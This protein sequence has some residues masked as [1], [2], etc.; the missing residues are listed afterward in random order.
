VGSVEEV[1]AYAAI[2]WY[3]WSKP[4][5]RSRRP[6][7]FGGGGVISHVGARPAPAGAGR[8][9]CALLC[10]ART[11]V[12]I[13]RMSSQRKTS[14]KLCV[15]LL[16][17]PRTRKHTGCSRRRASSSGARLL[18]DPALARIR[19]HVTKM[20]AAVRELDEEEHIQAPQPD[21]VYAEEVA[22]DDR[23]RLRPQKL[24][25]AQLRPQRRRFDPA[26]ASNL[27]ANRRVLAAENRTW[28]RI[29]SH[30]ITRS[31]SNIARRS[32][33]KLGADDRLRLEAERAVEGERSLKVGDAEREHVDG[34]THRHVGT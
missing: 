20:D 26:K 6:I 14:S 2:A 29:C 25:P 16:S 19:G 17:R 24:R 1:A 3:S 7:L 15:N 12:R 22:G 21:A 8:S 27:P 4:P 13:T 23:R 34:G 11:A 28:D 31:A 33:G 5:R 10:G 9:A 32:T 30:E 18:D